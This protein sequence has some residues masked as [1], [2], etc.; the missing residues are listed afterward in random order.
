MAKEGHDSNNNAINPATALNLR[1]RATPVLAAPSPHD[2]EETHM[3]HFVTK[4]QYAY[5]QN[6][7]YTT[8]AH[9][10]WQEYYAQL[11]SDASGNSQQRYPLTKFDFIHV[12][13]FYDTKSH[14]EPKAMKEIRKFFDMISRPG[15]VVAVWG[16]YGNLHDWTRMFE[17]YYSKTDIRTKWIVDPSL[18]C[19]IRH[20]K[21]NFVAARGVAMKSMTEHFIVA[22]RVEPH[23]KRGNM[24][25]GTRNSHA[26][27][28]TGFYRPEDVR[29]CA[30]ANVVFEYLPPTK[31]HKLMDAKGKP[32]RNMSEKGPDINAQLLGRFAPKGSKIFDMFA[33]TCSLGLSAVLLDAD[34]TYFG[35]ESDEKCIEP[36]QNRLGKG[37][38]LQQRHRAELATSL[39]CV[40]SYHALASGAQTFVLPANNVPQ[41]LG[42]GKAL[43]SSAASN[44]DF[45]PPRT[46]SEFEIKETDIFVDDYPIGQGLFLRAGEDSIPP[47]TIIPCLSFF[48]RF[49]MASALDM[50]FPNGIPG[51]P[52]CFLMQK[53]LQQYALLVDERCPA[54]K[55]NDPHRTA[56]NALV[57][58]PPH[59]HKR[60]IFSF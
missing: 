32:L 54:A 47:G 57:S 9:M 31:A 55:I 38:L 28:L 45:Y 12:D 37:H 51:W 6:K 50:L 40:R 29:L 30:N 49:V 14:P 18:M 15:T 27:E 41:I 19:V 46:E 25:I 16:H 1:A 8:V 26:V 43:G 52:G 5:Q 21:R 20:V 33:G 3:Q 56:H 13:P 23:V 36:A 24:M 59:S 11:S 4:Y 44:L 58:N 22:V 7:A 10:T 48:G 35:V 39:D 42:S 2:V 53:P 34:Y 17:N 60:P